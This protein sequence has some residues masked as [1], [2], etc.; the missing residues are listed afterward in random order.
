MIGRESARMK[1]G[2]RLITA[3]RGGIMDE[4]ALLDGLTSGK[5][6][7]IG[8][9][10]FTA[11]SPQGRTCSRRLLGRDEVVATPTSGQ[12][13]EAQ[14]DVAARSSSRRIEALREKIP[15]RGQ[16]AVPDGVDYRSL[17]PY[18]NLAEKI[19]RSSCS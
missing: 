18:M 9:P 12:H 1:D 10:M 2:V 16:F 6:R 14:R 8:H 17:A 7:R 5:V 13:I 4:A 15:E 11:S 19:G 3:A